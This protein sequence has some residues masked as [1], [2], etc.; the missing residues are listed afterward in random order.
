MSTRL[1]AARRRRQLLTVALRVFAEQ[2]F[3]DASMNDIAVAAGVTKPVLYQHF[4][5]KRD[6]FSELLEDVGRD[7]QD[8]I[9]KAVAAAPGPHE[10]VEMGFAAYFDYVNRHRDAFMLFYGGGIA[11]DTEFSEMVNQVERAVAALVAGLIEIE[12]LSDEARRVLGHGIVGMIEGAS[13]HWL[14]SGSDA[15]PAALAQQLAD[16]AWKGLRGVGP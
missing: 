14:R 1:P 7:L 9:T 15:D 3:H 8:T 12:G 6:L 10:M 16:L 2:G 5:S 4:T 11:R 13:I